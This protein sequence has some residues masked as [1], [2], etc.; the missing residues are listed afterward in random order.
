MIYY[1]S[2]DY[3]PPYFNHDDMKKLLIGIGVMLMV[4]GVIIRWM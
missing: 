1:G 2:A 4:F 3:Q